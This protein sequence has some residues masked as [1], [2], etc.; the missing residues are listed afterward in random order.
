MKLKNNVIFAI[1]CFSLAVPILAKEGDLTKEVDIKAQSWDGDLKAGK[2]NYYGNV[3]I[4][5]GSIKILAN[6]LHAAKDKVTGNGKFIAIGKPATFSQILEDGKL[7]TASASQ[8]TYEQKTGD[9][10][11]KGDA[12]LDVGGI[13][14]HA[15]LIRYNI[16]NQHVEA[17]SQ[18]NGRVQTIIPAETYQDSLNKKDQK[19]K[20]IEKKQ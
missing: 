2:I 15:N 1:F 18:N 7:A 6:T 5:Q 17:D 9:L 14:M 3:I 20:P 12:R 11:L 13:K 16:E 8:V 19:N 10:V 4:T